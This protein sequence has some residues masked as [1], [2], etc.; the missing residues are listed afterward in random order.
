MVPAGIKKTTL[1]RENAVN[2]HPAVSGVKRGTMG[3][4]APMQKLK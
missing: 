3:T 1:N 4:S 2:A